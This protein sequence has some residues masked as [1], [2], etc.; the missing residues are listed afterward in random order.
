[1]PYVRLFRKPMQRPISLPS[2]PRAPRS[3]T[4][5]S[6]ATF[7]EVTSISLP[8]GGGAIRDMGEKF[9]A[10]PVTRTSSMSMPLATNPGHSGLPLRGDGHRKPHQG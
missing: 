1:M 6:T 3:E 5:G 8:K 10:N 2:E 4:A 7:A 9:A